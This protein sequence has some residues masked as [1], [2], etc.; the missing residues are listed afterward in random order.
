MSGWWDIP[1]L[2]CFYVKLWYPPWDAFMLNFEVIPGTCRNNKQTNEHMNGRM[3]RRKLYTP[4]HKCRGY[5]ETKHNYLLISLSTVTPKSAVLHK[6]IHLLYDYQDLTSD[7][8]F[9]CQADS[10]YTINIPRRWHISWHLSS[11]VSYQLTVHLI[12]NK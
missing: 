4:W 5:K 10:D 7:C 3:E 11:R 1:P 9:R 12:T 8:T 2:R 6:S